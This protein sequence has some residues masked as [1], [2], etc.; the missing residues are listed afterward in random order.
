M[1]DLKSQ[2]ESILFVSNK[3][4]QAKA[5]AKLLALDESAVKAALRELA[6]ERKDSGILILEA[7][8]GFQL[9]TNSANAEVIKTFLNTDL[10][11]HLT[12]ASIEVLAIIAYRQPISRAEIEA[13]RGVN[14]QYSVR[15]LLIRGLI[16]KIPDPHDGRANLYQITTEFLQHLGLTT[17][18]DLPEF[19]EL[20]GQV[21]LPETP[22][23]KN[24]GD[25]ALGNE[26]PA[27][28]RT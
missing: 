6:A 23:I 3:P 4:L 1:P 20:A 28:G 11:E 22:A 12:D 2:L 14:S 16:E 17:I 9:A 8:E 18:A 15:A 13:I 24:A 27:E 10:R 19:G 21:K 26:S 5:L 25:S 7:D